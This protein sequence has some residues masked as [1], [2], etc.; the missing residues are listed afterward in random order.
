MPESG[1]GRY[2]LLMGALTKLSKEE[3]A[4]SMVQ[5]SMSNDVVPKDAQS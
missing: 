3:C 4:K 5:K 1:I 2:V